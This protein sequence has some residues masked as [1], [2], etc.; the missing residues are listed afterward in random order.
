MNAVA[1]IDFT[2]SAL[3]ELASADFETSLAFVV[4][5]PQGFFRV[6]T[7]ADSV[8]GMSLTEVIPYT[9]RELYSLVDTTIP[10]VISS[11]TLDMPCTGRVKAIPT[12]SLLL[13]DALGNSERLIIIEIFQR[14]D[15]NGTVDFDLAVREA[16]PGVNT[17]LFVL[18]LEFDVVNMPGGICDA[19]TR[20]EVLWTYKRQAAW[21]HPGAAPRTKVDLVPDY[22][23]GLAD[24]A[25]EAGLELVPVGVEISLAAPSR[26]IATVE[27]P[28]VVNNPGQAIKDSWDDI[29]T[30]LVLAHQEPK[31]GDLIPRSHRV[32]T[33]PNL[34]GVKFEPDTKWIII[35]RW[36]FEVPFIRMYTRTE[37][38]VL[39]VYWAEPVALDR[40]ISANA[41]SCAK[42]AA[43]TAGVVGV[44]LLNLTAAAAAFSDEFWDCMKRYAIECAD[45]RA[46]ILR[47]CTP[48]V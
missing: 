35:W 16:I 46:A 13:S 27:L 24:F 14:F 44:A 18:A 36:K 47:E 5:I 26:P 29:V 15:L 3:A 30:D 31:C 10:G 32:L 4:P 40:F 20:D 33:G 39:F 45:P 9:R 48:W 21:P 22:E 2:S 42:R 7:R 1:A 11:V 12:A 34:T 17:D 43:L 25:L 38:D 8:G 6:D 19:R 41:D 28:G 37:T 23:H